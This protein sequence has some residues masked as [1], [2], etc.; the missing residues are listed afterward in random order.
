MEAP[1]LK[2]T[3]NVSQSLA[4]RISDRLLCGADLLCQAESSPKYSHSQGVGNHTEV[5]QFRSW[6]RS[7]GDEHDE[8]DLETGVVNAAEFSRQ[9]G[10]SNA[11][12]RHTEG[13]PNSAMDESVTGLPAAL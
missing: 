7:G 12:S 10:G 11:N 8:E 6:R 13:E 9:S 4:L 1:A 5:F 2:F 3:T